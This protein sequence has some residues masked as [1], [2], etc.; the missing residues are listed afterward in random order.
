MYFEHL[1]NYSRALPRADAA[2]C[3][4]FVRLT[5]SHY[6][7]GQDIKTAPRMGRRVKDSISA[8]V[9]DS[10]LSGLGIVKPFRAAI[11]RDLA[12]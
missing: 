4:S 9:T 1:E 7:I 5:E 10:I 8:R 11:A 2:A 3:A 6:G 12:A